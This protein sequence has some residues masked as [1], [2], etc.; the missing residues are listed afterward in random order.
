[1]FDKYNV[2]FSAFF[3]AVLIL[4]PASLIYVITITPAYLDR[5]C[6]ILSLFLMLCL[7]F[8]Y[9]ILLYVVMSKFSERVDI[10]HKTRK[11]TAIGWIYGIRMAFKAG[12]ILFILADISR[13]LMLKKYSDVV[14]AIP[15]LLVAAY[16]GSRG[17]KGV[18]RFFEA[19]F[20]FSVVSGVVLLVSSLKNLDYME[21]L[22]CV[23]IYEEGSVGDSLRMVMVKGGVL[24]LGF[25]VMEMVMMVYLGVDNRRRGMLFS[26]V[27]TSVIIGA[28]G[29]VIVIATLGMGALESGAKNILYVVGAMELPN[30]L[31]IRPL[32]LVCYLVLTC[33]ISLLAPHV[34]CGFYA[35]TDLGRRRHP[36]WL[37]LLWLAVAFGVCVWLQTVPVRGTAMRLA[38]GYLMLV[39][40][41]LSLILPAVMVIGRKTLKKTALVLIAFALTAALPGC[42]YD[43]VESVDYAN[44]LV[45]EPG[46]QDGT[47]KYTLVITGLSDDEDITAEERKYTAYAASFSDVCA[48]YDKEH[49]R[50]L[51]ISHVEYVVADSEQVLEENMLELGREFATSYVTVI[52][53]GNILEKSGD[54]NTKDY[55]KNHYSGRCL[56][57]LGRDGSNY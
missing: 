3:K 12:I 24:F 48:M 8:A 33:G 44:V 1:M 19:V 47:Y 29:S 18:I 17:F 4:L 31:K 40:V 6:L 10:E 43:S 34:V 30:G 35:V 55:L 16:M 52:V 46:M 27:G 49:A 26:A 57:T 20:W 32:M 39:D 9:V 38:A 51:D 2:T 7:A 5:N 50:G 11:D 36:F 56:A 21:L 54:N 25:T 15:I 22:E 41:P 53:G 13:R 28:I 45:I 14:I 42:A 23:R 37:K